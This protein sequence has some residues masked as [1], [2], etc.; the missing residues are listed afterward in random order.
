MRRVSAHRQR[1]SQMNLNEKITL[2]IAVYGAALSSLT[3]LFALRSKQWHVAVTYSLGGNAGRRVITFR[4]VNL[5]ERIVALNEFAVNIVERPDTIV[6]QVRRILSI[7]Y[8]LYGVR[9]TGSSIF[10]ASI[11]NSCD[12]SL[13]TDLSPGKAC[14]IVLD[15]AKTLDLIKSFSPSGARAICGVF[16]DATGRQYKSRPAKVDLN[17][18]EIDF[19]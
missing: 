18:G 12:P 10:S 3:L 17:K 6:S 13:P 7:R 19:G 4:A 16:R 14:D 9:M 11:V 2:G 8:L 1:G 15:E 5:G